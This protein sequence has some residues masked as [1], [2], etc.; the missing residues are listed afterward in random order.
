VSEGP[1]RDDMTLAQAREVLRPLAVDGAACPCC[2]QHVRVYRRKLTAT[3]AQA[4]AE[5]YAEHGLDFGHLPTV[6]Q[7]HMPER[8]HQGGYLVLGAHWSLISEE[9]HLRP[10]TGRAGYW[11]VTPL[12]EQWLRGEASVPK[13]A[14]IYAGRCLGLEGDLVTVADVLDENFDF[15]E[16]IRDRAG[17]GTDDLLFTDHPRGPRRRAA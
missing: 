15:A 10:D 16:L 13:Y 1:F 5:L 9:R 3:A 4:V 17:H 7:K 14:R 12:A 6:A 2:K 11:R 8:A